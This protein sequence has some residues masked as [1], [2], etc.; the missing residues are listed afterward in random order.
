[1]SYHI[2]QNELQTEH[3]APMPGTWGKNCPVCPCP[4]GWYSGYMCKWLKG[5]ASIHFKFV[6][7]MRPGKGIG[8]SS[9]PFPSALASPTEQMSWG[10]FLLKV[11]PVCLGG[12]VCLGQAGGRQPGPSPGLASGAFHRRK[13]GTLEFQDPSFSSH[14]TSNSQMPLTKSLHFS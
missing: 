3:R 14:S 9:S 10:T 1:M 8:K 6:E 2:F 13:S 11:L 5:G 7:G 12:G 4:E